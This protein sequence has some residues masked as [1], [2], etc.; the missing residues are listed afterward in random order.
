[1]NTPAPAPGDGRIVGWINA[2]K[3]L[4][5]T[6]VL[7]LALL[8]SLVVIPAYFVYRVL[9]DPVILDKFLSSYSETEDISGCTVRTARMRG[10]P[11]FWSVSTGFALAG[12][13]RYTVAVVL[14]SEPAKPEAVASYCATLDLIVGKL[15][16]G[17][18]DAR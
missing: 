10:G 5:V 14:S 13:D 4:T 18:S 16:H 9:N 11:A 2:A 6:Q 7:V 1:M 17:G 8:S 3:S 12:S 15:Q